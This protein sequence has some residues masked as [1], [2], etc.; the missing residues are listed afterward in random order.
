MMKFAVLNFHDLISVQGS[1]YGEIKVYEGDYVQAIDSEFDLTEDK[2][3]QV[4]EINDM[5]MITVM[6]DVN[7]KEVYT[8]ECFFNGLVWD[9]HMRKIEVN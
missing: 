7:K 6:N 8:V 1:I 2:R 4:I 9:S 3:Y 5:D